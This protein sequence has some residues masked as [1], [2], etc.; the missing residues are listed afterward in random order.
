VRRYHPAVASEPQPNQ[1]H[2]LELEFDLDYDLDDYFDLTAPPF[3]IEGDLDL[4]ALPPLFDLDLE[5]DLEDDLDPTAP[6]PVFF[7][8]DIGF[9]LDHDLDDYFDL[10]ALRFDTESDI[11][12]IALP[13][14]FDLDLEFDLDVDGDLER[15]SRD[16]AGRLLRP[17]VTLARP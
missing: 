14:L 11:H 15:R 13:P 12:L 7:D 5:S 16:D 3:D 17:R 9:D 10:T 2:D 1:T 6:L 4:K 8:L